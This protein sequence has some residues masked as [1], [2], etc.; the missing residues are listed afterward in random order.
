VLKATNVEALGDAVLPE[1]V[2]WMHG[3]RLMQTFGRLHGK[4]V[5]DPADGAPGG[6]RMP[7]HRPWEKGGVN[8]LTGEAV[9]PEAVEWRMGARP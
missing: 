5:A 6:A 8:S 9:P 3:R 7:K 2:R 1:V 4:V